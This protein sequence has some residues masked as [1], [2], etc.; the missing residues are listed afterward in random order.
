[1]GVFCSY[2][3]CYYHFMNTTRALIQK[4]LKLVESGLKN[5]F[6]EQNCVLNDVESFVQNGSKRIRSIVVLLYLKLQEIEIS[7]NL[8]NVLTAGELIH[9]ASLLHDDVIDNSKLR[10]G[11]QN[12]FNKYNSKISSSLK[13]CLI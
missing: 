13:K 3:S 6:T 1:M 5:L 7:D 9:N 2:R 4:E 12:I 11:K 8:I 10:R